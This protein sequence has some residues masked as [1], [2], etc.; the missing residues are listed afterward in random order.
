MRQ[1][2]RRWTRTTG[3]IM[4]MGLCAVIAA[5]GGSA[6][7]PPPATAERPVPVVGGE[8]AKIENHPWVVYLATENGS[9]FCGGT[10]AA[11]NKVITAAHC[12]ADQSAAATRVVAGRE[13]KRTQAG[14]V[15]GV[16]RVWRHPD[17][18]S[19]YQGA[20]VAV[21]TLARELSRSTLPPA[22][23]NDAALYEP[24]TPST[25]LGWGATSEGGATSDVLRKAQVPVIADPKCGQAYGSKFSPDAMVCAGRAEGGVDSC[26]GD[27]GGPLVARGK[28]IGIVSW[29]LGCAR[30]GNPGV[31]TEVA[32][33]S[34]EISAQLR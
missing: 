9:Q 4:I 8:P 32:A 24:G 14:T 23:S 6:A 25:V 27:S 34:A 16:D 12:M 33:Y 18:R 3:M 20:D 2:A 21:L 31:Y 11:P 26:Q 13:N 15:V 1:I 28:L 29:G 19:P 22:T 17:Y 10:L 30:P 7:A 5:A